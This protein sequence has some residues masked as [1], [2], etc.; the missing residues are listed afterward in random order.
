MAGRCLFPFPTANRYHLAA[1]PRWVGVGV[2][3]PKV[4]SRDRARAWARDS[5]SCIEVGTAPRAVLVGSISFSG[6]GWQLRVAGLKTLKGKPETG[7][8]A[9][10]V[11]TPANHPVP[12]LP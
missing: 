10:V 3:E 2:G 4:V 12:G 9:S 1:P 11:F 5:C 6:G 7:I 8:Y